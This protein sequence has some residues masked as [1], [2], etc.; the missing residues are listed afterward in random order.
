MS[1]RDLLH[2]VDRDPRVRRAF[3]R[4]VW[5]EI[6]FPF[7]LAIVAATAAITINW[8]G[9]VASSSSLASVFLAILLLPFLFLLAPLIVLVLAAVVGVQLGIERLPGPAAKAQAG[10]ALIAGGARRTSGVVAAPWAAASAGQAAV[11]AVWRWM[12]SGWDA[13]F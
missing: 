9:L 10:A 4:Q 2:H 11:S 8:G 1:T 5:L 6:Y 12:K 3:R 7:G 13:D